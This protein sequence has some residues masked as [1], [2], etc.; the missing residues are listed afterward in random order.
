VLA[1][2]LIAVLVIPNARAELSTGHDVSVTSDG[3]FRIGSTMTFKVTG[4][5][6][7]FSWVIWDGNH[8]LLA[9]RSGVPIG[10]N[11]E[12]LVVWNSGSTREGTYAFNVTWRSGYQKELTFRLKDEVSQSD[13]SK[14]YQSL[15]NGFNSLQERIASAISLYYD[16]IVLSTIAIVASAWTFLWCRAQMKAHRETEFEGFVRKL[17]IKK[18]LGRKP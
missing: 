10:F 12:T 18:L 11:N 5:N 16:S 15:F 4:H 14:I 3:N 7:T 1:F 17:D 13:I 8:S 9:G 2:L 6:E